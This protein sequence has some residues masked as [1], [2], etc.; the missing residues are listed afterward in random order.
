MTNYI[1]FSHKLHEHIFINIYKYIHSYYMVI[2]M[3][4][5]MNML[6]ILELLTF[7]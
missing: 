7:I 3:Y 4:K 1:I 2:H 5:Y 6:Q